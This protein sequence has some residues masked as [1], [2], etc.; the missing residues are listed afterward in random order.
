MSKTSKKSSS[1]ATARL[2]WVTPAGAKRSRLA[3]RARLNDE[4]YLARPFR[5]SHQYP[6]R[7]PYSG[8]N[9]FSNTGTHV[10]HESLFERLAMLWLDFHEDI[11]AIASQPM[12]MDFANGLHH[13]PDL[14]AL[15]SDHRQVVYD[16]KPAELISATAQEQFD[17]TARVCA[18]VGWQ[19]EV[20][21][22]FD[23]VTRANLAWL[24]NFRQNHY[25]PPEQVRTQLLRTL[26]TAMSLQEA[27]DSIQEGPP[28]A[29]KA[30]IYH[31]AWLGEI[32]LDLASS[33][34][35][36]AT[37]IRKAH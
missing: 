3:E 14:I 16:I 2:H 27:A 17:E 4:L 20:I 18:G 21:S 29:H 13:V 28:N 24:S 5:V 35:C 36:N 37:L 23:A 26:T 7:R 6:K 1:A 31:L 8:Q 10:W 12:Q 32:Q 19:Y 25:E 34:F 30:W 15:H 11:V 22:S 9:W 33:P